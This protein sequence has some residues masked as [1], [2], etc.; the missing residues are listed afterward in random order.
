VRVIEFLQLNDVR[1]ALENPRIS[2]FF[3][4]LAR[5]I[6]QCLER[7]SVNLSSQMEDDALLPD[8][9]DVELH[10]WRHVLRWNRTRF[11]AVTT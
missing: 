7:D 8:R 3:R 11:N 10:R 4:A 9:R 5:L 2:Q 6:G 1:A